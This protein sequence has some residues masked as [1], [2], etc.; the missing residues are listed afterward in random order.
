MLSSL[1]CCK[2]KQ[3]YSKNSNLVQIPW[4]FFLNRSG[5]P[6]AV[7][8]DPSH[9]HT[10][11][12]IKKKEDDHRYNIEATL[13][14]FS[15]SKLQVV[16][17]HRVNRVSIVYSMARCTLFPFPFL[18]TS[19]YKYLLDSRKLCQTRGI[20]LSHKKYTWSEIPR[21]FNWHPLV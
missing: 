7:V 6:F 21:C 16:L 3:N 18:P 19:D 4:C 1:Y 12:H 20:V 2:H 14:Y 13:G 9:T 5:I 17:R 8:T 15:L 11:T 10:H